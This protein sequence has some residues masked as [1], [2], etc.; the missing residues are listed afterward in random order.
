ME[1]NISHEGIIQSVSKNKITVT[2][3]SASACSSCHANGACNMAEMQEKQIDI[4]HFNGDFRPGQLVNIVGKARQ[5]YKAVFYGYLL[6]FIVVFATLVVAGSFI[7]SE[8]LT[9]ILSLAVLIPY[10]LILYVFRNKLKNSFE[11]EIF[12]TT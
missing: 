7:K 2:I 9:G 6:P 1:E 8:A 4:H 3:V 11:F 10:Y 12:P 5:G